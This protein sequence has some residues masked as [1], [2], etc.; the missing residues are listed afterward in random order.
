MLLPRSKRLSLL[1][2]R[3]CSSYL[4]IVYFDMTCFIIIDTLII[5]YLR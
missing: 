1:I 3:H 5:T 4:N 2:F